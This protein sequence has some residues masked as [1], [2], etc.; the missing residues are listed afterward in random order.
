M[1]HIKAKKEAYEKASVSK[2]IKTLIMPACIGLAIVFFFSSLAMIITLTNLSVSLIEGDSGEVR[3]LSI[4]F[5]AFT[6]IIS[7]GMTAL[8]MFLIMKILHKHISKPLI[9]LLHNI[10]RANEGLDEELGI[11]L[12][13]GT[14]D[15]ITLIRSVYFKVVD[16]LKFHAED[17]S[18]LTGLAEKFE[19][20]AHFDLLTGVLNRR[21]FLELVG[22]H[23][24]IA[25]KKNEPTFVVM[26]DLD[27]FKNVNDTYGHDAGDEVLRVIA[28]RVKE[29]VRPYDLFGRYG[30][31]EFI[32]Y[33][34]ASDAASA[35]GFAD[36]IREIIQSAPVH[37]E[38]IDIPV[39][40]SLGI[41]QS[42][43]S[44]S[45]EAALKLADKAL[46]MAKKNG[47]NRVEIL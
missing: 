26:M 12:Q 15:E 42:A 5:V 22:K 24:I 44:V 4:A 18:N 29:T 28:G 2:K 3:S 46:Y 45:F 34:S 8:M 43:P 33:V 37:F 40:T 9:E 32:M 11:K 14:K 27:H 31:E 21:R 30:G 20:S 6:L 1:N 38:G 47:R 25:A 16:Q 23:A 35:V 19:N 17:V 39:T 7:G 36:R 13:P 41:A 10:K